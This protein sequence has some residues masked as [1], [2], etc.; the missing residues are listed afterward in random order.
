MNIETLAQRAAK[1]REMYSELSK[2]KGLK[3]WTDVEVY[4][5][6]VSDVGDLGRLVLAK[7]GYREA[8]HPDESLRHELAEILWATLLLGKSY[9]VDVEKAFHEE[10]DRLE[11]SISASL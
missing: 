5:G 8:P 2:K 4:Q 10:M 11:K 6:L 1:I 7:A 9:N 3:E